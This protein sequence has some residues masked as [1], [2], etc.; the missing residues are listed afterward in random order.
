MQCE[1][2]GRQRTERLLFHLQCAGKSAAA[3]ASENKRRRRQRVEKRLGLPAQTLANFT[4]EELSQ[5]AEPPAKLCMAFASVVKWSGRGCQC[6]RWRSSPSRICQ[7]QG[8]PVAVLLRLLRQHTDPPPTCAFNMTADILHTAMTRTCLRMPIRVSV[9]IGGGLCDSAG[10][11]AIIE[12]FK[13]KHPARVQTMMAHGLGGL[14]E[15]N[16]Q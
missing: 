10:D 14:L 12:T 7:N 1:Q 2:R 6:T 15:V 9:N 4:V 13:Q 8:F 11:T 5:S 3:K 16:G